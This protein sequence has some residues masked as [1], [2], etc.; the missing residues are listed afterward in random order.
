MCSIHFS[1]Q[2]VDAEEAIMLMHVRVKKR[3]GAE[4]MEWSIARPSTVLPARR[5]ACMVN[6]IDN[7]ALHCS[8]YAAD[9]WMIEQHQTKR[10]IWFPNAR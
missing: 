3:R 7:R 2:L 4:A 1:A 10:D 6:R 8:I 5:T 9:P